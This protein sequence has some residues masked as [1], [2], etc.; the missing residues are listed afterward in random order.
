MLDLS[1]GPLRVQTL[2]EQFEMLGATAVVQGPVLQVS[3][4]DCHFAF[5]WEEDPRDWC[6]RSL[7]MA[8]EMPVLIISLDQA[9]ASL[10]GSDA[11]ASYCRLVQVDTAEAAFAAHRQA[12]EAGEVERVLFC[13]SVQDST[14]TLV[15]DYIV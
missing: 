2:V 13:L 12:L 1:I 5:C 11:D 14:S 9:L 10:Q 3:Q 15:C 6:T 7:A 8:P 4:Q